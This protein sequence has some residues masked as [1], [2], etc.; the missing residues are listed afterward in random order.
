MN[1]RGGIDKVDVSENEEEEDEEGDEEEEEEECV[2]IDWN[3]AQGG[4]DSVDSEDE[5]IERF[6][7]E[8]PKF[9]TLKTRKLMTKRRWSMG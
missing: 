1:K 9:G 5:D 3:V 7:G 8:M 6:E 2:E 4:G